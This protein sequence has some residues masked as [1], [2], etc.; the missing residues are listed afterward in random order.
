[1]E[2]TKEILAF[3]KYFGREERGWYEQ[4][5]KYYGTKQ[6][7]FFSLFFY[8]ICLNYFWLIY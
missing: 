6:K 5:S 4:F 7:M 2:I 8:F 1:M 3:G